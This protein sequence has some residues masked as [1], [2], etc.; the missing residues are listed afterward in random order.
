MSALTEALAIEKAQYAC[1][2]VMLV[3]YKTD[4]PFR[5]SLQRHVLLMGRNCSTAQKT[6]LLDRRRKLEARISSYEQRIAY[7]MKLDDDVKWSHQSGKLLDLDVH[8]VETSDDILDEYPEGWFTP[9]KERITLPSALAAGEIERLSM[10]AVAQVE[11]ELR[12]GQVNDS[13]E[14]LRLALGEKSLCFRAEVRNAN[15]QRTTQRAWGNIHKF[16]ADARRHRHMYNQARNALRLLPVEPEYLETLQDITEQDMKVSGDITEDNRFGQRS[17]TLPW[18]WRQNGDPESETNSGPRMQECTQ[19][20]YYPFYPCCIS[21]NSWIVYRV[22]W[23]RARARYFRWKEEVRL[24]RLEMEWTVNW[25]RS[26]ETSW[27][28]RLQDLENDER[29][30]GLT[31]YCYKQMGLWRRFGD[32]AAKLYNTILGTPAH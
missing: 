10:E 6:D 25:F 14:A 20:S 12:K 19:Y 22:S 13:L 30:E 15:S 7:I 28:E 32:N 18:F 1:S 8:G 2:F 23:L 29:E 11:A 16:D 17:D 21:A 27:R 9:E 3:Y 5:I 31:C 4:L 24:V 26:R